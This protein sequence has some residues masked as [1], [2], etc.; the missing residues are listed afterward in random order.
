MRRPIL[1]GQVDVDRGAGTVFRQQ[2]LPL[3]RAPAWLAP[4]W[5]VVVWLVV[6]WLVV[7]VAALLLA[8]GPAHAQE[9]GARAAVDRLHE[10]L[11]D[12]MR[13]ADALGYEG[14]R[15]ALEPVV[16]E[17]F[18]M[19]E[20]TRLVL[21][22]HWR[23]LDP[24]ARERMVDLL[25]RLTVAEYAARFDGWSGQR[26]EHVSGRRLDDERQVV[27]SRLVDPE[28]EAVQLDYLLAESAG[29]WGVVNV[30]ADGVSQLTLRRAEYD[31]VI[32]R[33][34]FD[35]LVERIEGLIEDYAEGDEGDAER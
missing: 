15:E 11:L 17:V 32:E 4:V 16:G 20:L 14:R 33:A 2:R 19:P 3:C 22:R 23:D 18:A 27:R 28:G 7:V 29:Q 9:A 6:V 21:G 26:F 30:F 8:G 12:V 35:T 24:G 31:S 34:G 13:E 5:F 25:R 10:A 1:S